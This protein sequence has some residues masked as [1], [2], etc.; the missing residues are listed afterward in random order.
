[1][2]FIHISDAKQIIMPKSNKELHRA[3]KRRTVRVSRRQRW[4]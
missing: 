1:M 3:R 2:P 4:V